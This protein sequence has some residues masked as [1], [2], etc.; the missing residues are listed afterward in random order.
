[1]NSMRTYVLSLLMAFLSLNTFAE[2]EEEIT[3]VGTRTERSINDLASTVNV[4]PSKR[5]E[6]E[7]SRD[8]ADLVRF[9]PGVS[10]GGTGS[11]FGLSGFSIR[12]IGGNRVL[13]MIDGIRVADEYNF[14]GFMDSRR[15]FVD[16]DSLSRAEIA[17]GPVSSLWGSDAL[18]GVVSFTTKS[19]RDLVQ[20]TEGT[21]ASAKL[22][23]SSVDSSTLGT[24][25]LAAANETV[26]GML[27][28]TRRDGEETENAGG[29][30]EVGP[31]RELSLIH[32]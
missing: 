7:L 18:G 14:G 32:I 9:E 2:V 15:D 30:S 20:D 26:S 10:V 1:M 16:I 6:E 19:A 12:G 25:T 3:V 31:A 24:L 13:T 29:N 22:G 11:R 27:I 4:I 8:I 21:H 23:Y 28:Y 17:R 5:I